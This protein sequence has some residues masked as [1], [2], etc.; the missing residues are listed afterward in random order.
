MFKKKH[1]IKY[2]N[3]RLKNPDIKEM[4]STLL[5]Q[6]NLLGDKWGSFHKDIQ[7]V[8]DKYYPTYKKNL[9]LWIKGGFPFNI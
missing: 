6:H 2:D 7:K 9:K 5:I 3:F 1:T 4:M 8:V